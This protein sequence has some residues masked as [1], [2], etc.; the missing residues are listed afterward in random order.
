MKM[1]SNQKIPGHVT[2]PELEPAH[3]NPPFLGE[4]LLHS[5]LLDF[6]PV[7][8]SQVDESCQL[9]HPPSTK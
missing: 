7:L 8:L 2:V 3:G 6:S 5:L 4:G 9:P 1:S